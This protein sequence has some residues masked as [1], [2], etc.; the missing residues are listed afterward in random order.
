LE[1]ARLERRKRGYDRFVGLVDR[2]LETLDSAFS[3]RPDKQNLRVGIKASRK[4]CWIYV[5]ELARNSF[6]SV[7]GD[8]M[9]RDLPVRRT[10]EAGGDEMGG[11]CPE[12]VGCA[13][14]LVRRAL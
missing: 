11:A 7:R 9:E 14:T 6:D 3:A 10:R 12:N 13:R 5:Q 2:N 1:L 8:E 4:R